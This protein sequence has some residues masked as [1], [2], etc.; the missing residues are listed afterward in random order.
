MLAELGHS[1]RMSAARASASSDA[2]FDIFIHSNS[3]PTSSSTTSHLRY[4]FCCAPPLARLALHL[5]R[6]AETS[7]HDRRLLSPSSASLAVVVPS[8]PPIFAASFF[9]QA[10]EHP[11]SFSSSF[12]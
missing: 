2:R 3:T 12:R 11:R 10:E 7:I 5:S 6:F 1:A 8:A 4:S 9:L